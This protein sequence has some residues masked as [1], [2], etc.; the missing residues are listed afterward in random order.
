[1]RLTHR[2]HRTQ[3]SIFA[4]AGPSSSQSSL[5][6][7]QQGILFEGREETA[8]SYSSRKRAKVSDRIY[9]EANKMTAFAEKITNDL[10]GLM[11]QIVT[12]QGR[13][14]MTNSY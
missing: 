1:M 3:A 7:S 12:K 11:S 14:H 8:Q 6:T 2:T 9:Q 10:A 4:D 13:F 5:I